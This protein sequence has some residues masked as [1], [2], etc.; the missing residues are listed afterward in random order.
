M[1]NAREDQGGSARVIRAAWQVFARHGYQKTSMQDIAS[2]AGVSKSVLFKYFQTKQGLYQIAFSLATEEIAAAD[3]EAKANRTDGETVF[4]ILRKTVE[5]RMN[6]FAHAPYVYSF[7]YTAAYDSDP[8][9]Q[10]LVRREMKRADDNAE[11]AAYR[12]I[13]S[14]LSS[15]QAKQIIFWISQGFL[16]EKLAS[17]LAD[18][19]ELEREYSEWIDVMER[20]MTQNGGNTYAI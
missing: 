1:R 14:D 5:A 8:F 6:L 11:D 18:P 17:G 2:C 19:A 3:A 15:K 9:V 7:A 13:R 12:G 10:A 16:G 20:M 4:D